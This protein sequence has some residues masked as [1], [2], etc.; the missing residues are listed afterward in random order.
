MGAPL[1]RRWRARGGG[2]PCVESLYRN[3]RGLPFCR[4]QGATML[5]ARFVKG[6]EMAAGDADCRSVDRARASLGA[7]R[8]RVLIQDRR[9][10]GRVPSRRFFNDGIVPASVLGNYCSSIK[11]LCDG[12]P[13][14]LGGGGCS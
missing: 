9:S 6:A 10:L 2:A 7:S 14:D 1:R 8:Q 5:A 3:P 13:P 11:L 4:L 12:V